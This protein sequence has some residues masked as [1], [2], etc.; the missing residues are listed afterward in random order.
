MDK[1]ELRRLRLQRLD[2]LENKRNEALQSQSI[3]QQPSPPPQ[4]SKTESA[5]RG[6]AQGLSFGF[7]DE[8]TARLESITKGIPYEQALQETRAAYKQAQ[9]ANPI[10]YT[11]SEFAGGVLPAL[12][13]TGA[14]QATGAA[15]LGRLALIGTGTGAL[16]GLGFSEGETAGEVAKDVAIGGAL[17]GALPVLG[18]GMQSVI[19]GV[20]PAI[21]ISIKSG[22]SAMTGKT[23]PYLEKVESQPERIKKI[24]RIFTGTGKEETQ[25]LANDITDL[26]TKNPF[27]RKA[28]LLS[29]RSYK[30]L[31]KESDNI[32][33]PKENILNNL[34][35]LA[36]D[37]NT[38]SDVDELTLRVLTKKIKKIDER[39]PDVLNG[40]QSKK[41]IKEIDKDIK[42]L[43]PKVGEQRQLPIDAENRLNLFKTIRSEIDVPLKTQSPNYAESM[44]PVADAT[45][46]SEYLQR[47]TVSQYGGKQASSKKAEEFI[48]QKLRQNAL[49][50]LETEAR[51]LKLMQKEL[52]K[53]RYN[54]YPGIQKLRDVNQTIADLKLLQEIQA[55]GAIGSSVT[56]RMLATGGTLGGGL[57]SI[58]GGITGGGSG[59]AMGTAIGTP[60]GT[61]GGALIAPRMEREGGKFAAKV[62]EKTKGIRTQTAIPE[63]TQ[64]GFAT[65]QGL[66][67]GLLDQFLSDN[68]NEVRRKQE[69]KNKFE[70]DNPSRVK[71]K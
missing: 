8:A 43:S 28:E 39:Y 12:I 29:N 30:I 37:L 9:E 22:L 55:T 5:L 24:E 49:T 14:T 70:A 66:Q 15:T 7:A 1:E 47:L 68:A 33:L 38:T 2:E 6:G 56:N 57:G 41:L 63:S 17:G 34:K 26:V 67:R 11:G 46:V 36:S 18:R 21:D 53:S 50:P 48:N 4:V 13:P 45:N 19:Q 27:G 58:I 25:K 20:K 44:K 54:N 52:E 3:S 64:R 23:L 69:M 59:A 51:T 42:A 65:Q 32:S 40:M 10:T 62:L 61:L 71:P 60:L 35:N 16:S 31:E